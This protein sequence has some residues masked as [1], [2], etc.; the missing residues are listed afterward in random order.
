[1]DLSKSAKKS[2]KKTNKQ[3]ILNYNAIVSQI[4]TGQTDNRL[5]NNALQ[6]EEVPEV[7]Q[8]TSEPLSTSNPNDDNKWIIDYLTKLS[9]QYIILKEFYEDIIAREKQKLSENEK[10]MDRLKRRSIALEMQK[11]EIKRRRVCCQCERDAT[12]V[13]SKGPFIV[14]SEKCDGLIESLMNMRGLEN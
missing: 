8:E 4:N 14:C 5:L 6:D 11:T 2:K 7:L 1:M 9:H 3:Q 13:S 10:E 12:M